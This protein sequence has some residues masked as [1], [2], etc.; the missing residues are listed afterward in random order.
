MDEL[1]LEQKIKRSADAHPDW[2]EARIASAIRGATRIAVRAVREGRPIPESFATR[3]V[4]LEPARAGRITID[5][6]RKRYDIAQAIRE[7]LAGLAP[8]ELIYERE[9]CQMTAGKDAARFRR[10]VDNAQDLKA[11]RVKLRLDPESS[12]GAYYWGRRDDVAA[13]VRLRDE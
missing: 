10:A 1:T 9:L 6:V 3:G 2:S 5:Q 4:P 11:H 8:G 13:V 7:C 12:E